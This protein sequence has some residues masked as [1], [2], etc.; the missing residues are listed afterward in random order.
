MAQF[1]ERLGTQV[2]GQH[3][4]KVL[5]SGA[6]RRRSL[7]CGDWFGVLGP[8]YLFGLT[9]DERREEERAKRAQKQKS[10]V[11]GARSYKKIKDTLKVRHEGG[12]VN[13][14]GL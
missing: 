9:E 10:W 7:V 13:C 5:K 1:H 4:D 6:I 3:M 2:H 11:K 12:V 8:Y 14:A